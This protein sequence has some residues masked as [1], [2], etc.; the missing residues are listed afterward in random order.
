MITF[1]NFIL[2]IFY[3]GDDLNSHFQGRMQVSHDASLY[4]VQ[5]IT[6]CAL[7]ELYHGIKA[8]LTENQGL[9]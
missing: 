8:D 1:L 5:F 3:L 7:H 6:H 4:F 2:Q 9:Q